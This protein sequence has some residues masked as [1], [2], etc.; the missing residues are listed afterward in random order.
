[1][2]RTTGETGGT[3][4]PHSDAEARRLDVLH[5]Y[6]LLDTPPERS[7]DDLARLAALVCETPSAI[8]T[9][10]DERRQWFKARYGF[11]LHETE[12]AVAFCNYTIE[13]N[14]PLL[15]VDATKDPRFADNPLVTADNGLRFYAGVAL[16]TAQGASLGALA[17][18]DCV[19]RTISDDQLA[20]LG[21][22][23]GQVMALME[24]HRE[25]VRL[26]QKEQALKAAHET[27]SFHVRNSPLGVIEWDTDFRVL[28]W[29]PRAQEIFG[30]SEAEVVGRHPDN[31]NFVPTDDA[32]VGGET[33]R[34]VHSDDAVAVGARMQDLLH[35][36]LPRNISVNRNLTRDGEVLHCEWYN[37]VRFDEAGGLNSIFSLVHD[38]SERSRLDTRL[39]ERE[40]QL[41]RAQKLEAVGQLTGGIAHDFGNLLTVIL[42]NAELLHEELGDNDRLRRLAGL[43]TLA[44]RR[45]SEL[46]HRLL[47]FARQQV[48]E[49][50][51]VNLGNQ[52]ASM[53]GMLRR[54]LG[55]HINI[56]LK[57]GAG[58]WAAL[59][60]PGQFESALLNLCL[61]ARDVMVEGGVLTISSGNISVGPTHAAAQEG[62]APG[63]YVLVSV[64][65]TG[66]GIADEVMPHV[67]EPFYTTKPQGKG[68]GLG[69]SMVHGFASQSGGYVSIRSQPGHGTS[70]DMYL[71]RA[72]AQPGAD[73]ESATALLPCGAETILLVEDDELVRRFAV[74]QL[75]SLGY[76]V[77]QAGDGPEALQLLA[78]HAD[79]ELLFTDVVMPGGMN[80]RQLAEKALA[81][82]PGLKVLYTSG[83]SADVLVHDGRVA[84]GVTLLAKPYGREDLARKV[85]MTLDAR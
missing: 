79:I 66:T 82:R 69:L 15:V 71:P 1:M 3:Q 54:T 67:F 30:W 35:G 24:L 40:Q 22:L 8:V 64:I 68:T 11:S 28:R 29:S 65:D 19:P 14:E 74:S 9:L 63:E 60:D 55:E 17:V 25:R 84:P 31:W 52:I 51:P 80:G 75:V 56:E 78:R 43:I 59:V 42:C 44:G 53:H 62:L 58:P 23:G 21:I 12:R 6:R 70:V 41:H 36:L 16:R 85:R 13:Q 7:F 47:A 72:I 45:G 50:R 32:A 49:P 73:A 48:L 33:W 26:E 46:T 20:M 61:N 37:S 27:L 81:R 76:R 83:Y 39:S 5:S 34:F 10:I 18:L 38:V 77:F 57:G 4:P 2:A